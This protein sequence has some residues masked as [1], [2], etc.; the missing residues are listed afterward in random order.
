MDE[1]IGRIMEKLSDKNMLENSII[2]FLSDNGAPTRGLYG[3][4][5]SNWPLRGVSLFL[6]NKQFKFLFIKIILVEIFFI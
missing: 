3:N 6:F 5:G 1:S 2:I 4:D